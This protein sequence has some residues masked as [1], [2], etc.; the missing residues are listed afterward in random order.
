MEVNGAM[1]FIAKYKS[2]KNAECA[3]KMMQSNDRNKDKQY[4]IIEG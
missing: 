4:D 3:V 2:K 1:I